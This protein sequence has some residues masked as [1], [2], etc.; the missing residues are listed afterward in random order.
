MPFYDDLYFRDEDTALN[1][2][3]GLKEPK[4]L[5]EDIDAFVFMTMLHAQVGGRLLRQK[6]ILCFVRHFGLDPDG[7]ENGFVVFCYI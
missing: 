6:G 1:Y 5:Y 2:F 4:G 3:T 7:V